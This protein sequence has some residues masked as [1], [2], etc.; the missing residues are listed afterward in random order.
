M[1]RRG[2][3]C[4][5]KRGSRDSLERRPAKR[6]HFIHM[7][8]DQPGTATELLDVLGFRPADWRHYYCELFAKYPIL[9]EDYGNVRF[10]YLPQRA[11][12]QQELDEI[13]DFYARGAKRREEAHAIVAELR[14]KAIGLVGLRGTER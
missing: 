8:Q 1:E 4:H 13:A 2:A 7:L 14:A 9:A 5:P 11:S 12:H 6:H 10:L 3:P